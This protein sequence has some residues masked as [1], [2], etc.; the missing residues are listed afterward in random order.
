MTEVH[1]TISPVFLQLEV[2]QSWLHLLQ[3]RGH[4]PQKQCDDMSK[5]SKTC[6]PVFIERGTEGKGN[7]QATVQQAGPER[8]RKLRGARFLRQGRHQP[9]QVRSILIILALKSACFSCRTLCADARRKRACM[10]LAERKN[11]ATSALSKAPSYYPS[12]LNYL[13][14]SSK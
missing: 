4:N 3:Q 2:Q 11:M 10:I 5:T 6:Q 9:V 1:S 8:S 7:D 12:T 14:A 13:S